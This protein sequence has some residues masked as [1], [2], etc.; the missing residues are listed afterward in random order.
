MSSKGFP[1]RLDRKGDRV[2]NNRKPILAG[3]AVVAVLALGAYARDASVESREDESRADRDPRTGLEGTWL[4]HFT[5]S[6]PEGFPPLDVLF[7]FTPGL[8]KNAGTLT[9]NSALQLTP[10]PVCTSDQ[11]D[12][13]RTG[14][15][16]YLATAY[17]FCFDQTTDPPGTFDGTSKIRNAVTLSR[18]GDTIAIHQYVE[19]FDP[20]GTLVFTAVG[21]GA[22]SRVAIEAP[23]DT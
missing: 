20:Q 23:P 5:F 1:N 13:K 9:E 14:E 16:A 4:V 3:L 18:D 15:R 10:N 22:G 7:T 11:G 21:D 17:N 8:T 19:G 12:W 6:Q 2:M